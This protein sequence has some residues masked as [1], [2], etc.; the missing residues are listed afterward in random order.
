MRISPIVFVAVLP[1]LYSIDLNV[2]QCLE[3][4]IIFAIRCKVLHR[5]LM[6]GL[7]CAINDSSQTVEG[8]SA[9]LSTAADTCAELEQVL[10]TLRRDAETTVAAAL[11]PQAAAHP[12]VD[13][14]S[15]STIADLERQNAELREAK[16]REVAAL[17][18]EVKR[19]KAAIGQLVGAGT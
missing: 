17:N 10:Q 14:A 9:T 11:T 2:L 1:A 12:D 5:Q 6:E 4:L 15:A 19:L 13:G 7:R 3:N 8:H 18:S 16:D